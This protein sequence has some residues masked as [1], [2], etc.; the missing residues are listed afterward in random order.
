MSE[1]GQP[2]RQT[3]RREWSPES[4][5]KW[6]IQRCEAQLPASPVT[7]KDTWP[8]AAGKTGTPQPECVMTSFST[9]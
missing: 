5:D 9:L 3:E 6:P 2:V 7:C 4:S 1:E 8:A